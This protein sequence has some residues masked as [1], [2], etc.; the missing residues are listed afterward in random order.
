MKS[1]KFFAKVIPSKKFFR[2]QGQVM[3][4]FALLIPVLF[5]FAG[6]GMD[7]GWYYLNVSRMQNA[8]DAAAL[9]GARAL[10]ANGSDDFSEYVNGSVQLIDKFYAEDETNSEGIDRTAGD[11]AA[12]N[13][14]LKNLSSDASWTGGNDS[15]TMTDNWGVG[16]SSKITMTP[17]LYKYGGNFYY[18]VHLKESIQHFFMPGLELFDSMNAPVIA[19]A[20]LSK[21]PSDG[22]GSDGSGTPE[23]DPTPLG[24]VFDANG[25]VFSDGTTSITKSIKNPDSM[26]DDDVSDPLT[27][28]KG[29]PTYK[30]NTKEFKG[31]WSLTKNPS[32]GDIIYLDGTQLTKTQIKKLFGDNDTV[33][34]YAVWEDVKPHNNKTLW[35]QMHYLIAKNVYDPDW[36]VSVQKYGRVG[37]TAKIVHNSF[38]TIDKTYISTYHY[39]TELINLETSVTNSSNVGNET[40]YFIDFRRNDWLSVYRGWYYSDTNSRTHSLFNVNKAYNVRS[41][42]NDDPLYIRIE[43]EPGKDYTESATKNG[44]NAY[45]FTPVRQI[46]ININADNTA[47]SKRPLFFYYD[48]PDAVK[49][50]NAEPQPVILNLNAN[51]KGVLFMP[52]VPVVINGNGYKFEGFIVASEFRYLSTGGTQVKYSSDGKTITNASNNKIRINPNTGD[53]YSTFATGKDALDTYHTYATDP[54]NGFNLSSDSKFRQFKVEM[55]I[56]NMFMYVFYDSN[57]TMDSSNFFDPHG[58]LIPL[59]KLVDGNQVRVTKWEDVKLFDENNKEISK[60]LSDKNKIRTVRLDSSGNPSPLYDEAKNPVYFCEDYQK[61]TGKYSIFTLDR[62]ADGTR[63]EK[64]FLLTKTDELNVSNTDDWK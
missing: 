12:A 4:L 20:M 7:L 18:V 34:L 46:I 3:A 55:N 44:T 23:P 53:V 37:Q 22:S 5:I 64:E 47:D 35:E 45:Y 41:G 48:G 36:D 63:D 32:D 50:H 30:S 56:P 15:Y 43:A 24:I 40:R 1:D 29:T 62:V 52:D 54:T 16:S 31:A 60:Q 59:Y 57:M 2:Q 25:G 8:A 6:V 39:Y 51:F 28:D 19:V 17:T 9:A 14:V 49:S 58:D 33:T 27:S 10:I 61:L 21:T 26:E 11:E 38:D 42:Y 13:Y